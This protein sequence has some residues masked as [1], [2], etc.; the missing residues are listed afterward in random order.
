MGDI[1]NTIPRQLQS[2]KGAAGEEG[3]TSMI[4]CF[5]KIVKNEGYFSHS[6]LR[7]S[8]Q[9]TFLASPDYTAESLLQS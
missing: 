3:Y 2:G 4:D 5:R 1:S 7:T 8:G 9:Q 6:K